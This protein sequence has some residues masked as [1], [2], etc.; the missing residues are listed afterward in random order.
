MLAGYLQN[1][2]S[3]IMKWAD[4]IWK[5]KLRQEKIPFLKVDDVHDEWQTE[6][7]EEYAEYVMQTQINSIVQA[8]EELGVNCPLA[9]S[10]NIGM[11]WKETH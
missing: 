10:G 5:R 3:V 8:G 4:R 6:V 1:G 7:P 2:E 9:G 11:N